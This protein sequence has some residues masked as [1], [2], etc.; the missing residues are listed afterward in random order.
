MDRQRRTVNPL[1]VPAR[2]NSCSSFQAALRAAACN[3][4]NE[5]LVMIGIS[6]G[7]AAAIR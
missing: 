3:G 5:V 4:R 2:Y 7:F 1:M 6:N